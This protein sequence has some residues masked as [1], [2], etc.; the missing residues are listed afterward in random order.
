MM[1]LDPVNTHFGGQS[2]N[3]GQFFVVDFHEGQLE[4]DPAAVAATGRVF[5][6]DGDERAHVLQDAS[7]T[8]CLSMTLSWVFLVEPFQ[9]TLT[10]E[11]TGTMR[12]AQVLAPRRGK[13][14][15]GGQVE[16]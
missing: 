16:H 13:G 2:H 12:S 15:V 10:S 5:V 8:W 4:R 9:D 1:A 3:I 11:V 14:A 6:P 7:P